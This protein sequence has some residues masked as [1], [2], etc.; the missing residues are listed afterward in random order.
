MSD[1]HQNHSERNIWI[2]VF[3]EIRNLIWNQPEVAKHTPLWCNAQGIIAKCNASQDYS[4]IHYCLTKAL[5]VIQH[6]KLTTKGKGH[7]LWKAKPVP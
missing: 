7:Y 4:P 6:N 5:K 1:D 2:T 3:S